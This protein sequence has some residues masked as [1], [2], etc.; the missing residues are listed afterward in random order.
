[1]ESLDKLAS[2]FLTAADKTGAAAALKA[3]AEK[4]G[5]T[6]QAAGLLY[7]KFAEKAATKVGSS[8]RSIIACFAIQRRSW[9]TLLFSM[10]EICVISTDTV[11]CYRYAVL[12]VNCWAGGLSVLLWLA[13]SAAA[14]ALAA[15]GCTYT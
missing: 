9:D 4:L 13:G 6:E 1:V 11:E 3:A 12:F 8:I 10:E 5:N 15:A 14:M 2:A 7:S